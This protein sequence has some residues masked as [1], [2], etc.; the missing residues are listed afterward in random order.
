MTANDNQRII[1]YNHRARSAHFLPGESP[2]TY[3]GDLIPGL[4]CRPRGKIFALSQLGTIEQ[5]AQNYTPCECWLD[6]RPNLSS[7]GNNVTAAKCWEVDCHVVAGV[8]DKSRRKHQRVWPR[9]TEKRC[10]VIP[11]LYAVTYDQA[12]YPL[13]GMCSPALNHGRVT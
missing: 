12:S 6:N 13:K 9:S 4:C 5:T 2:H 8:A 3:E 10:V 7:V 1:A 11:G